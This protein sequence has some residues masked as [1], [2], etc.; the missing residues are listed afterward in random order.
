MNRKWRLNLFSGR[1]HCRTGLLL[2]ALVTW[3]FHPAASAQQ[4][5][6]SAWDA[7]DFRV[8]GFI[9]NWTPQTQLNSF[10]V[11]GVYSHVSDVIYFGGVQPR[12]DGSLYYHPSAGQHLATL[13]RHAS[14]NGFRLHVSMFTVNG[15]SVETVWN[16]I[17][18]NA[19]NRANFV[20]NVVDLMNVN[21]MVGFNLDWE[22]PD[23]VSEWANYTQLA[24][25]L[26]AAL[27]EG[28][29]VS[30]DDYGFADSRWDDSTT[31]DARTYDQLFIMGY[32][33]PATGNGSLDHDSFA[34]T[35]L[36]LTGQGAARA[37]KDEQL[38]LGIGTWG[39]EG[40]ATVS[41]KNIVAV[42]PDLPANAL[43]FTGTVTDI[44]GVSR[45]GTWNIES[46]YWVREK[47]QLALDRNM[48]GVMSWTLH[49]DATNE[50]S[51]HRVA[52]HYLMFQ[53]GIPDLNLDGNVS[54]ADAHRLADN[55]GT[56]PGWT[57]TNTAARFEDFYISGNWEQGD[58]DGN[59]FVNQQ[60]ADWL[61]NR[62]TS[63]QVNLPDRLPYT[64][65][66][67]NFASSQG[68]DGRW[69]AGRNGSGG[70][71]E[72]GNFQQHGS[73]FLL[74]EAN[75]LGADKHSDQF[76]TLRNQN[77]AEAFD[78]L[79]AAP[80]RMAANID[81]PID[82][83]LDADTYVTFLVRQ[84]TAPL[85]ASQ[86]GSANRELSLQFLDAAEVNQFDFA[87]HGLQQ[88][89]SIRSQSDTAG[90]DAMG[91]EFAPD[92]T[93]L[94]VGKVS[95]NGPAANTLQASLF[96]EGAEVDNFAD[97]AFPWMLTAEGSA[98][99]NPVITQLQ[100]ESLFEANYTVSN[101]W[102]G[103]ATDF[104]LPAGVPG[105]YNDDGV[106]NSADY[107]VWRNNEGT[108]N[109]LPNDP[110]GGTIGIAQ[111]DQWRQNFGSTS[112]GGAAISHSALPGT[113][114]VPHSAI[115]EP[116]SVWMCLWVIA[117]RTLVRSWRFPAAP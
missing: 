48:A 114:W 13:R 34:N 82:L 8:W 109:D 61:A 71:H 58:R 15:G 4:S 18:A 45:T 103:N 102:I 6:V 78:G 26:K 16:S 73:G 85:L 1:V 7:A 41:L 12:A 53:R 95:G 117:A 31:F 108:S 100:F 91:G 28:R 47:V 55:M 33:Y 36:A 107:I 62:F 25:D 76:V 87:L 30:V 112:G 46:R 81:T 57:G 35:K 93:F 49:Y 40:P 113:L 43:T 56:V 24:K 72:T 111:Y 106:V 67:E 94:F 5:S 92:A 115:P 60:D 66:F 90:D 75:G 29:E 88:Q 83:G 39:A 110:L 101:V 65:T 3:S 74:F 14:G 116:A 37:F 70:L 96:A 99:F 84:N 38:V 52:H 11:D 86:V 77:A 17:T 68:I 97:P 32:H 22:R 69:R 42:D 98:D 10:P 80:R 54:A 50:L 21:G 105:D 79:N 19:T 64:G 2:S 9:P 20:A 59:G 63:L 51:L 104:G 44:N 27:G 89:F 23:T